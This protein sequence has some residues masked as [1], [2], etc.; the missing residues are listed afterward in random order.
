MQYSLYLKG[1]EEMVTSNRDSSEYPLE[2]GIS[3]KRRI[4]PAWC[5]PLK[6]GG[7]PLWRGGG[8]ITFS[9]FSL[10]ISSVSLT[11]GCE[12]RLVARGYD[13]LYGAQLMPLCSY[14]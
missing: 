5:S 4:H 10:S 3:K 2:Y 11:I 9:Q 7:V 13:T 8:M 12:Y 14:V 1:S 6:I